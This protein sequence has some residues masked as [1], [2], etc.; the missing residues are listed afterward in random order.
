MPSGTSLHFVVFE[1][2]AGDGAVGR[3][4]HTSLVSG[5]PLPCAPLWVGGK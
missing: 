4:V 3:S 2:R 5:T 1:E